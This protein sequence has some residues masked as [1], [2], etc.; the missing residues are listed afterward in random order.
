[1]QIELRG[2]R[3][4]TR[5]DR[6]LWW[7]ARRTLILADPHFGNGATFRRAGI[8]VPAATLTDDLARLSQ[9][10][11]QTGAGRLVVLGDFFHAS[12]EREDPAMAALD[13]WRHE[14]GHLTIDL[15]KGNHDRHAG[16]PPEA[17]SIGDAGER[18]VDGPLVFRHEPVP[19][20]AGYVLAGHLHPAVRLR[21]VGRRATALPCFAF[22]EAV[23][24]LPAFGRFTGTHA[25]RPEPGQRLYAIAGDRVLAV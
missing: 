5:A 15:I 19:D 3:L 23:G 2:E 22:G 6:T 25:V 20:A 7:P 1:M 16:P 13:D 8:P 11:R 14:F 24:V 12:V 18:A 9:A 21:D 10:V 4:E 17:W